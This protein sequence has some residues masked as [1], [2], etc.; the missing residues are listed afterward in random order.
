MMTR[1]LAL[2]VSLLA[3]WYLVAQAK[4]GQAA[5]D[6]TATDLQGQAHRL[7]DYRGKIVVL[8]AF[9][10]E[11]PFC[12]NHYRGGAMQALQADAVSKGV[13]WLLFDPI[14]PGQPGCVDPA[15]ARKEFTR[16]G[17][18]ASAWLDDRTGQIGRKYGVRTT[19]QMF[20]INPDG[21]L[22]YQGAIDDQPVATGDPRA[23]RNYV[24]AAIQ[25]LLASRP[26]AVGET[27]PYGSPV[28][29]AN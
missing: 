21:V 23:A 20:V 8:E 24:R 13:V 29:Y 26:V 10:P 14:P 9:N 4:V 27:K 25:A 22:V 17:S 1:L 18:K 16:L 19:P 5:P 28:K 2:L 15:T 12:V 11:S 7:S 6:F 3:P